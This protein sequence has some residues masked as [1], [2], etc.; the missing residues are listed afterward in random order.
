[1]TRVLFL[2]LLLVSCSKQ[3]RPNQMKR[4]AQV[5][6]VNISLEPTTLDPRKVFDPSHHA[7]ISMLFEGLTKLNSDLTVSLAQ[8]ESVDISPDQTVYTFKIGPH[9]WSN[10]LAVT[11]FDFAQTFLNLLDPEF[12]APCAFLF[13]D[14]LNAKECKRGEIGPEKVGIRA[15]DE[16][17]LQFTLCHKSPHFLHILASR[18]LVPICHAE[19]PSFE[20]AS[21]KFISNGPFL[22]TSWDRHV[23]LI[24][25]K[26]PH[27]KGAYPSKLDEVHVTLID[28]EISALNMYASGYIDILGS[29]FSYIPASYLKELK[30]QNILQIYPVAHSMYVSFNTAVYPFDNPNLRKAFAYAINRQEI[31]EHISMADDEPALRPIPSILT[32]SKRE[33]IK[34]AD[35]PL[36][37][38]YLD[39]AF[40]EM[41]INAKS[42]EPLTLYYWHSE[43]NCR[44]AQVLQKQ[45][46]DN[47]GID[48][49]IE[50]QDTMVIQSKIRDGS[51]K[52]GVFAWFA[53]YGDPLALL[54]RT[55]VKNNNKNYSRW[56]SD[57][58]EEI[59]NASSF[60]ATPEERLAILE[61]AEAVLIDEMPFAPI[62]HSSY[63]LLVKPHV[64]GFSM[65]PLGHV[66]FENL[67][68]TP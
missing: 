38:S 55:R 6:R 8:A 4:D 9:R 30:N 22:L 36:A 37:K 47:L 11:A 20:Q 58:Y 65:N 16:K 53:E 66:Q 42:L 18:I 31:V 2:F 12:P 33:W 17:T 34:D 24:L 21:G 10:G 62:F 40:E 50:L 43:L 45:W 41:G 59:L 44:L 60:A 52:F 39:K 28:N 63:P 15:L 54:E 23:E 48:V 32:P 1:M 46:R 5:L 19:P 56:H 35:L 7:V 26:N 51:C 61:E 27:Y 13:N 14:V 25:K 64:K 49:K 29:P 57:R 67:S 3:P 68:I